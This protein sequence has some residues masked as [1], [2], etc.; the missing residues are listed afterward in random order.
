[1]AI[2][3]KLG[4]FIVFLSSTC[5]SDVLST[6]GAIRFNTQSDQQTDMILNTTGLGIGTNPSGNLHVNGNAIVSQKLFIGGT[7]GSANLNL[8]GSMSIVPQIVSTDTVLGDYSVI[9]ANTSADNLVLTLPSA[10][11]ANGRTYYVKKI[12]ALNQL[13]VDA[14]DN[15]DSYGG[16]LELTLPASGYS[17]SQLISNGTQWYLINQSDDVLNV[18]GADNLIG[19][20]KLDE[21]TGTKAFDSSLN[22]THGVLTSATFS[23]NSTNGKINQALSFDGIDDKVRVDSS[24]FALTKN[25]TVT[26]WAFDLDANTANIVSNLNSWDYRMYLSSANKLV[27]QMSL[28]NLNS[29]YFTSTGTVAAGEWVHLAFAF[30]GSNLN[31]YINGNLD[32]S[33]SH[34]G[35]IQTPG[36]AIFMGTYGSGEYFQGFLDDVR[37]YNKAL[38]SA[39]IQGIYL[40]GL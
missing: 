15:I 14:S 11:A 3:M 19:W 5:F 10:S 33:A 25:F 20:W 9:L 37:V 17:Y 2:I 6:N 21:A 27:V 39:E 38:T 23:S 1:M 35:E 16:R 18:I 22:A 8:Q 7:S 12:S 32:R 30:D 31:M 28:D 4:I 13:W 26:A 34:I 24:N 29:G 40:L 36:S